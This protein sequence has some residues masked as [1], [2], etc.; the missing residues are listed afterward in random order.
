MARIPL[1]NLPD[2]NWGESLQAVLLAT[3]ETDKLHPLTD[4]MPSPMIPIANRPVMEIALEHL[5]RQGIKNIL[6]CLYRTPSW[7]ESY[8]G[9]GRRWGVRL[10]YIL[11]KDA[12]GN[13]GALSWARTLISEDFIVVPVDAIIDF[14]IADALTDHM[15]QNNVATVVVGGAC[16]GCDGVNCAHKAS[17]FQGKIPDQLGQKVLHETGVYLFKPQ[18]LD[19]IPARAA[20]DIHTQLLPALSQAGLSVGASFMDGY[21]NRLE[22]FQD[23]QAAQKKYL[24]SAMEQSLEP[25]PGYQRLSHPFISGRCYAPGIWVGKNNTIH[26][27]VSLIPPVL[28]GDNIRVGREAVIGPEVV[29]GS[30]VIIADNATIHFST[31]LDH[32]YLGQLV[33]VQNRLVDKSLI[34]DMDTQ[35]SLRI[36]DRFLLREVPHSLEHSMFDRVFDAVNSAALL[37]LSMPLM[38]LIGLML[39]LFSG[40]VIQTAPHINNKPGKPSPADTEPCPVMHLYR[41]RTRDDAGNYTV[42]GK[43]LERLEWHRLPELWNV[44]KGDMRLVG[45]KPLTLDEVEHL[46][47]PWQQ[48]HDDYYPGFT[49][50]W[51][52]Q[53]SR[54]SELDET[55]IADVY[56]VANRTH[57]EDLRIL[58]HTPIA[59]FERVRKPDKSFFPLVQEN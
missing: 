37:I 24:Y 36:A 5:A 50:L 27:S 21:W 13:A 9:G 40:K 10:S 58:F 32:S 22:T 8:F 39:L 43:F 55:L 25:E 42:L 14:D 54:D 52:I 49:G 4:R 20:Y 29:I 35:A 56:Y 30:N 31:I 11:L 2:Q 33:H 51:F 19:Y 28:I 7:I 15:A 16:P 53:A 26:P 12:S 3:G 17:R 46:I 59:W 57:N 38:L 44:L 6:V 41:F 47:E 48:K 18:V 23:I 45:V 34:I 1:W